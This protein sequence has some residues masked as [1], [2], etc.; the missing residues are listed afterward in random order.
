MADA[1]AHEVIDDAGAAAPWLVLVHGVSQ[2]RRVWDRQVEAFRDAYRLIL[3]DMPGHGASAAMPGPFGAVEFGDAI[4]ASLDAAGIERAV[5]WGTHLGATAGLVLACAQPTRFSAMILEG[6]VYP[7]RSMPALNDFLAEA[8]ATMRTAGIEAAREIWWTRGPWFDVMRANPVTCRAAAQR[9]IVDDFGGAPW[10]DTGL[11][12][13]PMPPLDAAI[14]GLPCPVLLMNG[15]H[16]APDFL[17]A[18]AD[19][20]QVLAHG[21]RV[22]IPGGGGFPFWEFPDAVNAEVRCFLNGLV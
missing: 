3:I 1:A 4:G 19:L 13:R 21:R 10:Q 12:S 11:A 20:L 9:A 15:E 7:G 18:S 5:Y 22:L 8:A 16:D 6:P 17:A 2:D 14:R